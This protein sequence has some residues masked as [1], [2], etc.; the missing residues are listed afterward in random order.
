MKGRWGRGAIVDH[1]VRK[2]KKEED[3]EGIKR[4][5]KKSK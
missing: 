2:R 4:K 3:K 5:R 1:W